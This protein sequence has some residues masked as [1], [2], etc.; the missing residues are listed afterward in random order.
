MCQPK[1]PFGSGKRCLVHAAGSNAEVR[2]TWAKTNVDRNNIYDIL[3][4]LNK[5]GKKLDA[6]ELAEVKAFLDKEKFKVTLDPDLSERDRKLILKNLTKAEQEIVENPISGGNFHAWK[7]V[8]NETV[9]RMKRPFIALGIA[10]AMTLSIAGCAGGLD[11]QPLP[12]P[13]E[14][15]PIVEVCSTENP[16]PF[17]DSVLLREVTD[18]L[19]TYCQ[20]TIDPDS[21]ALVYDASVVDMASLEENGFTEEDVKNLQPNAVKFFAEEALD[22]S[23][24][25]RGNAENF[26]AWAEANKDKFAPG[27]YSFDWSDEP[28]RNVIYTGVLTQTVRDGGSR[29]DDSKIQLVQVRAVKGSDELPL[30]LFDFNSTVSYRMSDKSAIDFMLANGYEGTAEQLVAE[31]PELKLN[32]GEDNVVVMTANYTLAYNKEG[33]I[34]GNLYNFS[35]TSSAFPIE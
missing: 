30:M 32:D 1:P 25:D 8:F 11:N 19:G 35:V 31:R 28:S 34:A 16:G 21:A 6:P 29:I 17:G 5:E 15:T 9:E 24:L 23:M 33:K 4:E 27:W 3:R 7:N 2:Y 14:T 12:E 20:T 13:T 10:G 22:S 18:E 26:T